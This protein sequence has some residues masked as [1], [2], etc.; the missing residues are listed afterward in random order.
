[1]TVSR[2]IHSSANGT[3][4]FLFLAEENYI[5]YLY[6]IFFIH[7]SVS[8][9]LGCFHV[10]A[11]INS[12]ALSIGMH[13]AFW[14]MVFLGICPGVGLL[15]HRVVCSTPS[16]KI[17]EKERIVAQGQNMNGSS[18]PSKRSYLSKDQART[19]DFLTADSVCTEPVLLLPASTCRQ[20]STNNQAQLQKKN[21]ASCLF[22]AEI[23]FSLR[24]K[25]FKGSLLFKQCYV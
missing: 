8:R 21:S 16:Y 19:Q 17:I 4:S 5:V 6:H 25:L 24:I 22:R 13:V 12:A 2:S 18:F 7:F 1:M 14:I 3:I 23:V 9:H 10:L 20:S 11:I 15:G